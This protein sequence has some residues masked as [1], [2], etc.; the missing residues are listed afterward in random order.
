MT[1]VAEVAEPLR[2][3]TVRSASPAELLAGVNRGDAG[4]WAE[5]VERFSG[6]VWS[7]ARS[8]CADADVAADV[9]QT[10]WLRLAEHADRI[11][12]PDRL[13]AWLATTARHEAIR[14]SKLGRRFEPTDDFAAEA[15]A[16]APLPG[17]RLE[18]AEAAGAVHRAFQK[19][20]DAC[21]ELL[22]LLTAEPKLDYQTIAEMTGRPIGSLGPTRARCLDKLRTL[23]ADVGGLA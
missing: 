11:R 7:V 19:L 22:R 20:G 15:D 1:S 4:A 14:L 6:L 13:A 9:S 3:V 21:R 2:S 8:V 18:D 12:E 5:L 10:V 17:E 23:L 16:S